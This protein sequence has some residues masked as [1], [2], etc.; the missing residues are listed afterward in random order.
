[1]A[2]HGGFC[3]FEDWHEEWASYM[4][5]LEQYFTVNDYKGCREVVCYFAQRMLSG[6]LPRYLQSHDPGEATDHTFEELVQLVHT[7]RNPPL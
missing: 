7:H 6:N 4:E 1:M 2:M 5:R 3:A